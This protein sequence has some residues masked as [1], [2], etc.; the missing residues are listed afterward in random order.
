LSEIGPKKLSLLSKIALSLALLFFIFILRSR[1]QPIL[2]EDAPLLPFLLAVIFSAWLG[3]ASLGIFTSLAGASIGIYFFMIPYDR[4]SVLNTPDMIRLGLYLCEGISLSLIIG[5]LKKTKSDLQR[6]TIEIK[7]A[8]NVAER[9]SQ[10]KSLFLANMSHEI[11]TPMTAILGFTELLLIKN[12]NESEK[13]Q[14]LETIQRNAKSLNILIDDILDLSKV[15]SGKMQIDYFAFSP[16]VLIEDVISLLRLKAEKKEILISLKVESLPEKLISDPNKIKQIITN[17]VANAIKFTGHGNVDVTMTYNKISENGGMLRVNVADTG[18]GI[19]DESKL[20]LFQPFSQADSSTTR[21]FGGTGL[22][23]SLSRQL[24]Q[25]LGGKVELVD[26]KEDQGSIFSISIPVEVDLDQNNLKN[27][28]H[29][30]DLKKSDSL[31]GRKILLVED[32]ADNQILFSVLLKSYG[33]IVDIAENGMIGAQKAL[34]NAYDIILMD[35]QMPEMDGFKSL[36]RIREVGYSGKVVALT[37]HSMKEERQRC[38]E[39]GFDGFISKPVTRRELL[40]GISEALA[41]V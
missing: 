19:S 4:F 8:R 26:S 2:G 34:M 6:K 20:S 21:K 3:N 41:K 38:I 28:T 30:V 15:E 12:M 31:F 36:S 1:A 27:K 18:I 17:I 5:S 32:S 25:K 37:A 7:E 33:A 40:S 9:A 16:K 11:R 10:S 39:S 23:L 13:I 35:I 22:G 24:A 14:Y 29:D